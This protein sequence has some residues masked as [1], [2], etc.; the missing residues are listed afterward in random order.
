MGTIKALDVAIRVVCPIHGVNSNKEISFKEEATPQQRDQAQTIANGWILTITDPEDDAKQ[1]AIIDAKADNVV[2]YLRDHTVSECE[3]YVQDNVTDL[4]TAKE[5]LKK[6]AA[7]LCVLSK[8][9]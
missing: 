7:V 3:Q 4:A 8:E 1:Q 9:L 5:F 6:V 2:Q